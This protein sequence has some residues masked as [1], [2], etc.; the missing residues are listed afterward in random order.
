MSDG[1]H[2]ILSVSVPVAILICGLHNNEDV[3]DRRLGP[4]YRLA[5]YIGIVATAKNMTF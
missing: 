3:I 2:D 1:L 5:F 4:K